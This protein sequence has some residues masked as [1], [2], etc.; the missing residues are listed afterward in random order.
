MEQYGRSSFVSPVVA[1]ELCCDDP[2]DVL[3]EHEAWLD[4][5]DCI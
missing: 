3:E 5:L 4:V 2:F 1:L